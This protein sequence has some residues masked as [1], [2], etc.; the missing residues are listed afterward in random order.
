MYLSLYKDICA[1][2]AKMTTEKRNIK[3]FIK[4]KGRGQNK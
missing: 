3:W 1:V 4:K 2:L